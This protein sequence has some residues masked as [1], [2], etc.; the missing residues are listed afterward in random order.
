MDGGEKSGDLMAFEVRLLFAD[1]GPPEVAIRC[2]T[3]RQAVESA[4]EIADDH[5]TGVSHHRR[6]TWVNVYDERRL[7]LSVQVIEGGLSGARSQRRSQSR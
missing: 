5:G 7:E 2:D 1:D 3:L 6:A 4:F